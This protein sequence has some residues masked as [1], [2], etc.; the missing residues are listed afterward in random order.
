VEGVFQQGHHVLSFS[1]NCLTGASIRRFPYL[2]GWSQKYLVRDD[3]AVKAVKQQMKEK[4]KEDSDAVKRKRPEESEVT[5][6]I[7]ELGRKH[8]KLETL[9]YIHCR[10]K[11]VKLHEL[12]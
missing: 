12:L 9:I 3:D 1:R 6:A 10:D 8:V 4:G 2:G 5:R 7:V 11:L